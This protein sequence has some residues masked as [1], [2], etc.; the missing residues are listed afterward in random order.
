MLKNDLDSLMDELAKTENREWRAEMKKDEDTL[1]GII[2]M[3]EK[4]AA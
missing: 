4:Q 1:R 3:L 2:E